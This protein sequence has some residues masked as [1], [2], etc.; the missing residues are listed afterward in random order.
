MNKPNIW[1]LTISHIYIHCLLK[2]ELLRLFSL[3]AVFCLFVF[4]FNIHHPKYS[5]SAFSA[6]SM[7]NIRAYVELSKSMLLKLWCMYKSPG[8]LVRNASTDS[9]VLGWGL[10][11]CISNKLPGHADTAGS[12]ITP[13][14]AGINTKCPEKIWRTSSVSSQWLS[15]TVQ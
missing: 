12:W 10:A 4:F 11:F 15:A 7:Y 8:G 3:L 2:R 14:V 13:W 1:N 9:V 5:N 6:T